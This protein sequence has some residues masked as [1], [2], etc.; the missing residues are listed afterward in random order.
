MVVFCN[1]DS[2]KGGWDGGWLIVNKIQWGKWG[3]GGEMCEF[4][5]CTFEKTK[6][7]LSD[8]KYQ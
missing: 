5:K 4:M 8:A 2:K 7:I 6:R 3:E 1:K